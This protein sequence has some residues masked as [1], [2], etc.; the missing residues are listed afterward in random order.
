[1]ESLVSKKITFE[2]LLAILDNNKDLTFDFIMNL[3]NKEVKERLYDEARNYYANYFNVKKE[4][5][6]C[7]NLS[8][9]EIPNPF[10]YSHFIGNLDWIID[11]DMSKLV[12]LEGN[13]KHSNIEEYS[14]LETITGYGYF[15]RGNIKRLPKLKHVH[16]HL[17][18]NF[19]P[20]EDISS[21]EKVDGDF[22]CIGT[23]IKYV[24]PNLRIMGTLACNNSNNFQRKIDR[25]KI[26]S[27]LFTDI[28]NNIIEN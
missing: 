17:Y 19:T 22:S 18:L 9:D 28:P 8:G 2:G 7:G 10:P 24:N 1:M 4:D 27:W 11:K 14:N 23:N 26:Q 3:K 25:F 16:Q 5:V 21:L 13:I 15:D 20:I 6:W 12:Y